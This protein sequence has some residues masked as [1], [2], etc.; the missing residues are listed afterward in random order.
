MPYLFMVNM[1]TKI[2][3]TCSLEK[4]LEDFKISG[5]TSAGNE[6]RHAECKSCN[7]SRRQTPKGKYDTY[8]DC[9]NRKKLEFE[10]TIE[11]FENNWNKECYYC[12]D[13]IATIGYDRIDSKKGYIKDNIVLCCTICN[14]MKSNLDTETFL[15]FCKKISNKFKKPFIF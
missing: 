2:C 7:K 12:G 14:G 9:A 1:K 13:T 4:H 11:D 6:C 15:L 8:R 10:L 3:K 5:K